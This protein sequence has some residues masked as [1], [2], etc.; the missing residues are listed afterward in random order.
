[1]VM[2]ACVLYLIFGFV[3]FLLLLFP[4]SPKIKVLAQPQLILEKVL[5]LPILFVKEVYVP[6]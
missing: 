4:P 3:L 1:M 2:T 5:T 6:S